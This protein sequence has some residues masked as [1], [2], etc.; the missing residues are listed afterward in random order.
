MFPEELPKRCI[1]M[2][3]WI[4]ATVLDPF[5]GVG[6]TLKVAKNLKREYIGFEVSKDY[7]SKA[8]DRIKGS[9]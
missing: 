7:Y 8:L 1:K 3:S 2:F 6:T 5:A 4:G 9:D